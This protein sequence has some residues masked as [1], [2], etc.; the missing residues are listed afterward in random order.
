MLEAV[1]AEYYDAFFRACARALRPGGL[2][3]IQTIAIPDARYAAQRDGR[4]LDPAV[5]LPGAACSHRSRRSSGRTGRRACSSGRSTDVGPHYV[6]TLRAWRE[7]YHERPPRRAR[8]RL[9]RALRAY[10]GL[11][12]RDQRSGIRH[13]H[14][15]GTSRSC[16][17][18]QRRPDMR[19]QS[20]EAARQATQPHSGCTARERAS[21]VA[22]PATTGRAAGACLA[23]VGRRL[24]KGSC[25]RC[26]DRADRVGDGVDRGERRLAGHHRPLPGGEYCPRPAEAAFPTG[27]SVRRPT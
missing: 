14:D 9:R 19:A 7:R 20:I 3:A 23:R 1:G 18:S 24:R 15:A 21:A 10:V 2:A 16:S 13:A 6:P 12:P 8:A 26:R 17:R 25:G 4:E 5:H 11:L 22:P 27:P